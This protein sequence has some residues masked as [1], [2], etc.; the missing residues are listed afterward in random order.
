VRRFAVEQLQARFASTRWG[1][2]SQKRY[3][4]HPDGAETIEAA[5]WL[6]PA[7]SPL[8]YNDE[9]RKVIMRKVELIIILLTLALAIPFIALALIEVVYLTDYAR[10]IGS[11]MSGVIE[12]R[13]VALEGSARWPELG[14][15]I[16]GQL[17]ILSML[18]FVRRHKPESGPDLFGNDPTPS[19]SERTGSDQADPPKHL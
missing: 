17:L 3:W 9:Y 5:Q 1:E 7:R 8:R 2:T 19:S 10:S 16:I 12:W 14:G 18:L 13:K 11:A 15:M 6:I 4:L